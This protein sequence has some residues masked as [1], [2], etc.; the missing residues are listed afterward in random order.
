MLEAVR[1]TEGVQVT[2]T[3]YQ[4]IVDDA[5]SREYWE[6]VEPEFAEALTSRNR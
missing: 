2:N 6:R 4:D 5:Y 1:D 3:I